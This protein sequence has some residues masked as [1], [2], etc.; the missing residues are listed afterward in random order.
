MPLAR[1]RG[2]VE[3]KG[4]D[5]VIV[6]VGGVGIAASVPAPAADALTLGAQA[7][8]FTYL[9]VREDALTL[10]GFT[11]REDLVLFEQLIGVSGVGPRAALGLLSALDGASLATAIVSGQTDLL[12]KVPGVGQKTAER[13]VLELRDK[14]AVPDDLPP[15]SMT[16]QGE[17]Q[18]DAE[19]VSALMGL[20]YTQAEAV[21]AAERLPEDGD[22]TLEDRV[23][24][25]LQ[26]LAP[27]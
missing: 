11:S 9:H 25:V 26:S 20:G 14:V 3:E 4:A 27:R 22:A 1:L 7:S 23:R 17:R 16:R 8:L 21:S 19:L 6:G 10:Y 2:V 13:L 15:P 18:A 24:L 5:W 12:R